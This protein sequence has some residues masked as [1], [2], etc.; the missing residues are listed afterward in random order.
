MRDFLDVPEVYVS[1]LDR[2][3]SAGEGNLRVCL[4]VVR[5]GEKVPADITVIF[6]IAALP[7]AIMKAI[8]ALAGAGIAVAKAFPMLGQLPLM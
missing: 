5:A 3:E 2:F 1:G 4:Y 6:P 8:G 7:D